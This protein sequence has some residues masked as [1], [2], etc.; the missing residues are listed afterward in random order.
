MNRIGHFLIK[1][2][3]FFARCYLL[4]TFSY[5]KDSRTMITSSKRGIYFR[6]LL[7]ILSMVLFVVY[8]Y[9]VGVSEDPSNYKINLPIKIMYPLL[10]LIMLIVGIMTIRSQLKDS[11]LFTNIINQ[12][13]FLLESL[14]KKIGSQDI[15]SVATMTLIVMKMLS[16]ACMGSLNI[17]VMINSQLRMSYEIPMFSLLWLGNLFYFNFAFLGLLIAAIIHQLTNLYLKNLLLLVK[18]ESSKFKENKVNLYVEVDDFEK[19]SSSLNDT[20]KL[21]IKTTESHYF[22]VLIVYTVNIAAGLSFIFSNTN[23]DSYSTWNTIIYQMCCLIDVLLFSLV[24]AFVE[25]ESNMKWF[26]ESDI[27]SLQIKDELLDKK[28]SFIL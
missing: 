17:P 8:V 13:I 20:F 15:F 22:V 16:S 25:A 14:Q 23:A 24:A 28:V 27:L 11:V 19:F 5:K 2:M 9:L 21:F 18:Q 10:N 26:N 7:R 1:L 4:T 6:S 12:S 3:F